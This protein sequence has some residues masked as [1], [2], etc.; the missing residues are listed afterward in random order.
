LAREQDDLCYLRAVDVVGF[1]NLDFDVIHGILL[2]LG[3]S[4]KMLDRYLLLK[5]TT[6]LVIEWPVLIAVGILGAICTRYR[7]PLF[8]YSNIIGFAIFVI[9]IVIHIRCHLVHQRADQQSEKIEKLL[10]AGVFSRVRHPMYASLVL[11]VLGIALASGVLIALI[12]ATIIAILSLLTALKEEEFLIEKFGNEYKG[13]M[14][15]VPYR[16]IPKIL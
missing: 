5:P 16:F 3:R 14:K 2:G 9:G 7:I 1:G 10:T 6:R 12:P 11:I 15:R 8:P 4:M 13:Y